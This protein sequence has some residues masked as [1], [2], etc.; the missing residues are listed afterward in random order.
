M[1]APLVRSSFRAAKSCVGQR[2]FSSSIVDAGSS[3][4][5]DF[6]SDTLTLPDTPMRLAMSE[7]PVGDDVYGEDPSVNEIERHVAGLLGKEAAL[8]VPSGTMGN[9]VSIGAVC[10]RGDELLVADKS[11][12][13]LYEGGGASTLLG[14]KI[15]PLPTG[16]G[17]QANFS[18][19]SSPVAGEI[20]P[21]QVTSACF[22]HRTGDIHFAST[23]MLCLENTN[24][25]CGGSVLSLDTMRGELFAA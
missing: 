12:I 3:F 13:N 21:E 23:R 2:S 1:F 15:T 24:V 20:L 18:A 7:A 10:G 8:L 9:L 4:I 6:R 25:A 5:G 16:Y 14:A 17:S 11:H 19:A 22:G